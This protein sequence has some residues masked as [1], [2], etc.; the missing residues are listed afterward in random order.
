MR[1]REFIG[2]LFLYKRHCRL[3]PRLYLGLA[4]IGRALLKRVVGF[5]RELAEVA[6]FLVE[7]F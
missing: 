7:P 1:D 5:S 6:L 4:F 3:Q 2:L